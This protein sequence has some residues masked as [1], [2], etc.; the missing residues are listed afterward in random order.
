MTANPDAQVT[1][2]ALSLEQLR[3]DGFSL[4]APFTWGVLA[5]T[6][7]RRWAMLRQPLQMRKTRRA[8]DT[9]PLGPADVAA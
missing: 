3:K 4:E 2:S 7:E 9:L 8:M 5:A 1:E 6:Q